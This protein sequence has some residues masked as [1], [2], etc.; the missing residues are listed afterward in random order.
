MYDDREPE[1]AQAL[2]QLVR[3]T[4]ANAGARLVTSMKMQGHRVGQA[5]D[6][7]SLQK[8]QPYIQAIIVV[9]SS[10]MTAGFLERYRLEGGAA[11]IYAISSA[12]IEQ[13]AVRLPVELM[14][15]VSI[16]QVVPNPYRSNNK[17][18]KEFRDLV[19]QNGGEEQQPVS[20][21]MM[22]GFVNAKVLVEAMRRSTAP[23][24]AE[25]LSSSLRSLGPVDLGGYW[26]DFRP[27][28]QVG[29]KFVDLSI[30][31]AQGRVTQ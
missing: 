6:V 12:D 22:E 25:Q 14:R 2:E 26:V 28:A 27:G 11:Q 13:L 9:A 29:S 8:A 21:A 15:G 3:E 24:T 19:R 17:L 5:S 30:V 7:D 1:E 31:N 23:L 20:Y 16:A 10:P 4:V 18:S